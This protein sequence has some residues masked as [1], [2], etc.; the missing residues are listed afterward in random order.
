ME[1]LFLLRDGHSYADFFL[2]KVIWNLTFIHSD[3]ILITK[4]CDEDERAKGLSL[5]YVSLIRDESIPCCSV[6]LD[7]IFTTS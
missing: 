2:F 1:I 3:S 4:I 5:M 6:N 7:M